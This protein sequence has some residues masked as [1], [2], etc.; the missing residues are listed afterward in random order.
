MVDIRLDTG[1]TVAIK[2]HA[3]FKYNNT[4]AGAEGEIFDSF[5]SDSSGGVVYEVELSDGNLILVHADDLELV[6]KAE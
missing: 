4:R 5:Q 6:K 3:D 1:D 2:A